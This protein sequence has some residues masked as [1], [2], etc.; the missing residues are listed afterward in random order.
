MGGGKGG[1]PGEKH[2]AEVLVTGH[3][4]ASR[5]KMFICNFFQVG[6]G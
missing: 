1:C 6:F 2:A 3:I 5:L 4:H